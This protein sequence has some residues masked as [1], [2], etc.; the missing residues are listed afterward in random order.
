MA[1]VLQHD[2]EALIQPAQELALHT[3]AVLHFVEE[4]DQEA[5]EEDLLLTGVAEETEEED[6]LISS[7]SACLLIVLL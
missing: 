5:Q 6:A 1:H 7:I 4:A 3:V 2:P